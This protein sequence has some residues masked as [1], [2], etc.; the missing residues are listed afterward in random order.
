MSLIIFYFI[1][2]KIPSQSMRQKYTLQTIIQKVHQQF[3]FGITPLEIDKLLFSHLGQK[4][5]SKFCR[6]RVPSY[7]PSPFQINS[8]K[9]SLLF[10]IVISILSASYSFQNDPNEISADPAWLEMKPEYNL[11][12]DRT[13]IILCWSDVV[14]WTCG[15]N[16]M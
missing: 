1:L 8:T 3:Q 12:V 9:C 10:I 4:K 14:E 15:I 11:E 16:W 7:F 6:C 2:L 5:S 13:S